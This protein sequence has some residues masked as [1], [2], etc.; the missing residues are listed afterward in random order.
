MCLVNTGTVNKLTNLIAQL[1]L[2]EKNF[3]Y[4]LSAFL[5]KIQVY[6]VSYGITEYHYHSSIPRHVILKFPTVQL[7]WS[8][9]VIFKLIYFP[10]S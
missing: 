3:G 10:I 5:T 1:M 6:S 2:E 4:K 7:S 9:M 8:F